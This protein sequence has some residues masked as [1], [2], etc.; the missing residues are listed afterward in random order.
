MVPYPLEEKERGLAALRCCKR[1]IA[2]L[3]LVQAFERAALALPFEEGLGDVEIVAHRSQRN[4]RT[5]ALTLVVDRPSGVDVGLC[6]RLAAR[7]N[8]A[9]AEIEEPYTLEVESPGL[10][11]PLTKPAD[12][13]RFRNRDVRIQTT[14]AI[15]GAKTHRGKLLGMRETNIILQTG[16]GELPLPLATIK[17][18]NLEF[19]PRDDLKKH[20][21]ERRSHR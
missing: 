13:E 10:D 9:L 20:K 16:A 5:T 3:T 8:D 7:I 17:S 11:R 4:G 6:E 1:E 18:A 12:Y 14:I 15:G 2:K 19:D 21:R